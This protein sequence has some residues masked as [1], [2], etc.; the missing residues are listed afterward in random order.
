M[1]T[2][3]FPRTRAGYLASDQAIPWVRSWKGELTGDS[4]KTALVQCLQCIPREVCKVHGDD[5]GS[6]CNI[7]EVLIKGHKDIL[8]CSRHSWPVTLAG[9]SINGKRMG[10]CQTFVWLF[11]HTMREGERWG[12]WEYV[13]MVES[14]SHTDTVCLLS[15]VQYET[16]RKIQYKY[17]FTSGRCGCYMDGQYFSTVSLNATTKENSRCKPQSD[18]VSIWLTEAGPMNTDSLI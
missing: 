18:N 1:Q 5:P 7:F 6:L 2:Y 4:H 9:W 17:D 11:S 3:W 8:A 15:T 14:V 12:N 13:Q 10:K 16:S